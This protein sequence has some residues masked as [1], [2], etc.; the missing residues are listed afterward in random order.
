MQS[1]AEIEEWYTKPDPW[2]Y[3]GTQD[4]IDRRSIILRTCGEAMF[5]DRALD[6]G[7]G[8]G[9][10]TAH[11]PAKEIEAY[12]ISDNAA[13]RLPWNVRRVIKPT[14]KYDLIIVMGMMYAHYDFPM[15]LRMIREHADGLVILC[16]IKEWEVKEVCQLGEPVETFEFPYREFTEVMRVYDFAS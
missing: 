12:E 3:E 11:L 10:I 6:I 7:S 16:N 5:Y 8:E 4:D 13:A 15:F 9:F 14:G 1:K 2:G